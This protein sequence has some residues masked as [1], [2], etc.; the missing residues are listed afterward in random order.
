MLLSGLINLG[1]P[2]KYLQRELKKLNINFKIRKKEI[3]FNHLKIV[4]LTFSFSQETSFSYKEILRL[5]SSSDL[6]ERVKSEIINTYTLLFN[7]ERKIHRARSNDFKFHH[8]GEIDAILEI[9]GFYLALDY[10]TVDTFYVSPLPVARL[11]PASLE[12]L[13]GKKL[14]IL[15]REY[16]SITPTAAALLNKASQEL[17]V[18]SFKKFAFSQGDYLED[19][20]LVVYLIENMEL[21]QDKVIK[22]ETTI[23]DM[24]PQLFEPLFEKLYSQGARD[25]YIENVIGKKSRPAFVL[26]VLCLPQDLAK[27]RDVIFASTSTFGIRYKEY[28]RQKLRYKFVYRN[29][30]LGKVKFR[31]SLSPFKKE[32]PEYQDCVKIAKKLNIPLIEVYHQIKS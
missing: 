27:V 31:V 5:V 16:E 22:V 9:A 21:A 10:F 6:K 13:K 23:D 17:P 3:E 29:T 11:A 32:T 19:D 28:N 2:E 12:L 8:L 18:F 24:N 14:R 20:Y 30:R 26:N 25:V 15:N 4:K 7:V 1:Y